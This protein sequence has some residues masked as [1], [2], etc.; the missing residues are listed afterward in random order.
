MLLCRNACPWCLWW[1]DVV[2]IIRNFNFLK[3]PIHI[4]R[5]PKEVGDWRD[6]ELYIV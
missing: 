4:Y 5:W 6:K 2:L 1:R 3:I